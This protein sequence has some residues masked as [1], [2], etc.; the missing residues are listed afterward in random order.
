[1]RIK[2]LG[3][4][5]DVQ[6]YKKRLRD[7]VKSLEIGEMIDVKTIIGEIEE[8]IQEIYQLLEREAIARNYVEAKIPNYKQSLNELAATFTAT[9]EEVDVLKETYYLEDNDMERYL[10][11][12]KSLNQLSNQLHEVLDNVENE[13][14]SHTAL[15][16]QIEK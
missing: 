12:E 3:F 13:N 11:L 16:K 14:E 6:D 10:S 15:R 4:E 2:H 1:Y 8:R 9:K 5:K 7:T